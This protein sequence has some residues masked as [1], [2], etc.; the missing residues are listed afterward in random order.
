MMNFHYIDEKKII[1][2]YFPVGNSSWDVLFWKVNSVSVLMK[3]FHYKLYVLFYLGCSIICPYNFFGKTSFEENIS[4]INPLQ[5]LLNAI[6][7]SA[8]MF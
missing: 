3:N 2:N 4:H 8:C 6:L 7:N 5:N 1:F